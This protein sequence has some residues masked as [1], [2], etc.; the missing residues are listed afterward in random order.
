MAGSLRPVFVFQRSGESWS[1][2]EIPAM[3]KPEFLA[4]DEALF[5]GGIDDGR[6]AVARIDIDAKKTIWTTP[7]D[8]KTASPRILLRPS[9]VIL[10]SESFYARVDAEMGSLIYIRQDSDIVNADLVTYDPLGDSLYAFAD[11]DLLTRHNIFTGSV[12][13]T[14]NVSATLQW[15]DPAVD[16]SQYD[17]PEVDRDDFFSG[18]WYTKAGTRDIET[19]FFT[20]DTLHVMIVWQGTFG[21]HEQFGTYLDRGLLS[22]DQ[23]EFDYGDVGLVVT[24][25]ENGCGSSRVLGFSETGVTVGGVRGPVACGGGPEVPFVDYASLV[26]EELVW[27]RELGTRP[28]LGA[29]TND[30]VSALDEDAILH[31]WTVDGAEITNAELPVAVNRMLLLDAPRVVVTTDVSVAIFDAGSFVQVVDLSATMS[32]AEFLAYD[33]GAVFVGGTAKDNRRAVSRVDISGDDMVFRWTTAVDTTEGSSPQI[34]LRMNEVLLVSPE[35]F[36][37][38]VDAETG[39]VI[40]FRQGIEFPDYVAYDK[41]Q[42]VMYGATSGLL[43]VPP[44]VPSVI[45]RYDV[46]NGTLLEAVNVTYQVTVADVADDELPLPDPENISDELDNW[47]N[48][49]EEQSTRGLT[50]RNDGDTTHVHLLGAYIGRVLDE[51]LYESWFLLT[52]DKFA[53]D[54]ILSC[55]D[56]TSWYKKETPSKDCVWVH[57]YADNRC[58]TKIRSDDGTSSMHGCMLSCGVC[59]IENCEDNPHWTVGPSENCTSSSLRMFLNFWAQAPGSPAMLVPSARCRTTTTSMPGTIQ[60]HPSHIPFIHRRQACQ[61]ACQTCP[62]LV[63][64]SCES[65]SGFHKKGDETKDCVS[66]RLRYWLFLLLIIFSIQVPTLE[67]KEK[68][69][70]AL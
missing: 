49:R 68:S 4:Y 25:D 38:R 59:S 61:A 58:S 34:H 65:A 47:Y 26:T 46:E 64:D 51:E 60:H 69:S 12:V 23:T 41:V 67:K 22:I 5:V 18:N 7:V 48:I 28:R 42:D 15:A 17:V 43:D 63:E 32:T 21:R 50:V 35:T 39:A 57:E 19:V 62:P 55:A 10:V 2:E 36:Y 6:P 44:F 16:E 9:E 30:A 54:N 29:V 1:V 3:S 27:T 8:A 11:T 20:E 40:Y 24:I 14:M 66:R 52:L 53:D 45:E 56:D 70:A 13:R 31:V 33:A 37:A